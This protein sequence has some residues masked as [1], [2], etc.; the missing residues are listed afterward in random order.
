M[1][2]ESTASEGSR[3]AGRAGKK[4]VFV[5]GIEVFRNLGYD[6]TIFLEKASD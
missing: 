4:R 6:S 5:R 1:T 3:K 2:A